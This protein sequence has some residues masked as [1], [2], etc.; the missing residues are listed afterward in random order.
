[1]ENT[2]LVISEAGATD[3]QRFDQGSSSDGFDSDTMTLI[4]AYEMVFEVDSGGDTVLAKDASGAFVMDGAS[5]K[6]FADS[7]AV[8]D[9]ATENSLTL[10]AAE[11]KKMVTFESIGEKL[12]VYEVKTG[13]GDDE[14][15]DTVVGVEQL[16]FEDTIV[17]ES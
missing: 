1:M 10:T 4:R 17:V 7:T 13:S 8:S 5:V 2:N 9:Y 6:E 3:P 16:E 14:E 12:D 15:I 11:A